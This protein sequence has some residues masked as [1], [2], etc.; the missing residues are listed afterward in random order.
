VPPADGGT[1]FFHSVATL[2]QTKQFWYDAINWVAPPNECSF[3]I[4]DK[5]VVVY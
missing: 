4:E 1:D 5:Y 2:Y 3:K